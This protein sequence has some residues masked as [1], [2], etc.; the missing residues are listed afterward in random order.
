MT[1]P[2]VAERAGAFATNGFA[3]IRN[4]VEPSLVA[5]VGMLATAGL[6]DVAVSAGTSVDGLDALCS[7]W[8]GA[9]GFVAEMLAGVVAPLNEVA[10]SVAAAEGPPMDSSLFV[11]SEGRATHAHQDIAYKWNRPVGS[12]YALTTWLALDR[13]GRDRG[14]LLFSGAFA[15][16]VVV[17]RQDFLSAGFRDR[18]AAPAWRRDAVCVEAAPGDVVVFDARVWHASAAFRGPGRRRA[19]AVRWASRTGWERKVMV[20]TPHGSVD[21]FGMDSS[22]RLFVDAAA[23]A[24]VQ[25]PLPS[26]ERRPLEVAR[27]LLQTLPEMGFSADAVGALARLEASLTLLR[28]H[29]GRPRADVWLDVRD[30]L[31]PELASASAHLRNTRGGR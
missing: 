17:E 31:M 22:G 23:A 5:K 10:M 7:A 11:Q 16:D 14:G 30:V 29:D 15:P 19:L 25:L 6:Q 2:A 21:T 9:C 12:R 28:D 24:G 8:S 27:I 20:P 3:V 26:A 1:S 13:C 18:A 4:V